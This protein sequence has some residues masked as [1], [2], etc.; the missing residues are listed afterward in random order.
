MKLL[1]K[2]LMLLGISNLALASDNSYKVTGFVDFELGKST[3]KS[4]IA[5]IEKK[6]I[7][8]SAYTFDL[9]KDDIDAYRLAYNQQDDMNRSMDTR[10]AEARH[11]IPTGYGRHPQI[12][13]EVTFK[14]DESMN[15][16][17]LKEINLDFGGGGGKG[18]DYTSYLAGNYDAKIESLD[19]HSISGKLKSHDKG[20]AFN[21]DFTCPILN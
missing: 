1:V 20:M 17:N 21:L 14:D 9:S 11:K 3:F 6:S 10:K 8:I 16:K 15:I 12:Y 19:S 2:S 18:D 5:R 13:I 4:C 7:R